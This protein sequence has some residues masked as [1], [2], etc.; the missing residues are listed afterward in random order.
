[1]PYLHDLR[2]GGVRGG[3]VPSG[4][5][6][7]I[8]PF[9]PVR[10]APRG[11]PATLTGGKKDFLEG[12]KPPNLPLGGPLCNSCYLGNSSSRRG[13]NK[14]MPNTIAP[15]ATSSTAPAATSLAIFA[16]GW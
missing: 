11:Y 2:A 13:R 7:E 5:L 1:M 16:S 15:I 14:I 4:R 10:A 12:C 3:R 8:P 9:P 6:P